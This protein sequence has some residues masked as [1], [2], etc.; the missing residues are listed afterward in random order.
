MWRAAV[1]DAAA[2]VRCVF[3]LY[4]GYMTLLLRMS[5][6]LIIKRYNGKFCFAFLSICALVRNMHTGYYVRDH[7]RR[8]LFNSILFIRK[9]DNPME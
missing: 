4:Q 7:A 2:V 3:T 8:F 9:T 6:G 5:F 1:F